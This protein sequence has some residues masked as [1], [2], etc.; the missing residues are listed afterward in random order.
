M[1]CGGRCFELPLLK[2]GT[3]TRVR[4]LNLSNRAAIDYG[5]HRDRTAGPFVKRGQYL[6]FFDDAASDNRTGFAHPALNGRCHTVNTGF[7][8]S[9]APQQPEGVGLRPFVTS[10][11]RI[12]MLRCCS[13]VART[14]PGGNVSP[15]S[16]KSGGPPAAY[17]GSSCMPQS[18]AMPGLADLYAGCIGSC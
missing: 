13:E 15:Q 12:P 8:E 6:V 7:V 9:D 5:R 14:V 3:R 17:T 4:G 1:A 11:T 18:G 2:I 10:S 16:S